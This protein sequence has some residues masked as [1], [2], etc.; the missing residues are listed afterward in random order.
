MDFNYDLTDYKLFVLRDYVD[1]SEFQKVEKI[2]D[3][4]NNYNPLI[5]SEDPETNTFL[6]RRMMSFAGNDSYVY[7]LVNKDGTRDESNK[8]FISQY[9]CKV[10]NTH[11]IDMLEN[12]SNKKSFINLFKFLT[13]LVNF[14]EYKRK[15]EEIGDE[16]DITFDLRYN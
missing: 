10:W 2:E 6:I 1:L 7:I 4:F 9:Q 13:G 5:I 14:S 3:L 15:Q 12:N 8:V 11:V 16:S